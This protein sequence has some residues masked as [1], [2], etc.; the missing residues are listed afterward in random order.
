M[1]DPS[2]SHLFLPPP[3]YQASGLGCRLVALGSTDPLD[4]CLSDDQRS[5]FGLPL[6]S[7]DP[8]E[9]KD[10]EPKALIGL[11]CEMVRGPCPPPTH[12]DDSSGPSEEPT[13][14]SEEGC[15]YLARIS[16]VGADGKV[17]LDSWIQPSGPVDNYKTHITGATP[18]LLASAPY[19]VHTLPPPQAFGIDPQQVILCGHGLVTDFQFLPEGWR[20][21]PHLID[22]SILMP[23]SNGPPH[24]R[25]LTDL[26]SEVLGRPLRDKGRVHSSLDDARVAAL[27]AQERIKMAYG[28][29][30]WYSLEKGKP[31]LFDDDSPPTLAF[32]MD[33]LGSNG[34]FPSS[35]KALYLIGSR[36]V[37][38]ARRRPGMT[39]P[40]DWDFIGVYHFDGSKEH[41]PNGFVRYGNID[42]ALYS[43]DR[44]HKHLWDFEPGWHEAL[45]SDPWYEDPLMGEWR[46]EIESFVKKEPYKAKL[47]INEATQAALS[48]KIYTSK[49]AFREGNAHRGR[50][51]FFVGLRFLAFGYELATTGTIKSIR[52][53]NEVWESLIK[54]SPESWADL[55]SSDKPFKK[56]LLDLQGAMKKEGGEKRGAKVGLV[57]KPKDQ[58]KSRTLPPDHPLKDLTCDLETQKTTNFFPFLFEMAKTHGSDTVLEWLRCGPLKLMVRSSSSSSCED[59]YV[60]LRYSSASPKGPWTSLCRGVV[61]VVNSSDDWSFGARPFDRFFPLTPTTPVDWS[62][63]LITTKEDGS[64]AILY[65]HGGRWRVASASTPDALLPLG[66]PPPLGAPSSE[67]MDRRTTFV[68]EFWRIWEEVEGYPDPESLDPSLTYL[69]EL[70]TPKHVIIIRPSKPSLSLLGA[71]SSLDGK[72]VDIFATPIKGLRPIE[73]I[74]AL[75]FFGESTTDPFK[76]LEAKAKALDGRF[77]EGWVVVWKGAGG[78]MERA[79]VKGPDYTRI[80]WLCPQFW[81]EELV[82]P[83]RLFQVFL[84]DEVETFRSHCPHFAPKLDALLSR[85]EEKVKLLEE[86]WMDLKDKEMGDYALAVKSLSRPL[87]SCLFLKR[88]HPEEP[89]ET[90]ARLSPKPFIALVSK[91]K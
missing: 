61:L 37:G 23:H 9:S 64:L 53:M 68:Q 51:V 62:S 48:K 8:A 56:I 27:V 54:D 31:H 84:E 25:A 43:L 69:F 19:T 79:K 83:K 59:S 86:L 26:S 12:L 15:R 88:K 78:L 3:S 55:W 76:M 16:L 10:S 35:I 18:A 29:N 39:S 34:Y 33:L 90:L 73:A 36:G 87:R 70:V 1:A 42:L 22:T 24:F 4:Y 66:A 41:D 20:T 32:L 57:G 63:A 91:P 14:S 38:T 65:N 13:E 49:R 28:Y 82:T 40:P 67:S 74:P 6:G 30:Q 47:I 21:W 44:F 80:G 71:R 85:F 11:D 72:E 58:I 7:L 17:Y 46:K 81:H 77:E 50:S 2:L 5:I 60:S 89:W 45:W 52:S 75:E